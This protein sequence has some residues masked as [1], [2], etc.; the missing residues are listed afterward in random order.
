MHREAQ[1]SSL[2]LCNVFLRKGNEGKR[3]NPR[4][5]SCSKCR[6]SHVTQIV[7][8]SAVTRHL[9]FNSCMYAICKCQ[10]RESKNNSLV[11][12]KP[13]LTKE[14]LYFDPLAPYHQEGKKYFGYNRQI[15]QIIKLFIKH[16]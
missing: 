3:L 1:L 4:H 14:S 6:A 12:I 9:K 2:C 16:D 8:L 15:S 11:G 13:L 10:M 5:A 7:S